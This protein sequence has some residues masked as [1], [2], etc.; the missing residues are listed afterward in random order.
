MTIL[1]PV[2]VELMFAS[3]RPACSI[4]FPTVLGMK[5]ILL[6]A[7]PPGGSAN[8]LQEDWNELNVGVL[9]Q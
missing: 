3:D 2:I 4:F 8:I 1:K 5:L 6:C 9:L 7:L